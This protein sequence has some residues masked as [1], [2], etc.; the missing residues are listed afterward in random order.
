M[1]LHIT[2]FSYFSYVYFSRMPQNNFCENMEKL[3]E[4][5]VFLLKLN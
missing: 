5:L 4:I 2:N 1:N 3:Y